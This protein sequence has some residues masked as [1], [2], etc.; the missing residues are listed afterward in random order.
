MLVVDLYCQP[1]YI[2]DMASRRKQPSKGSGRRKADVMQVRVGDSEK[3][4]FEAAAALAGI[5]LSSWVRERLRQAAI[6]ELEA[7]GQ[8]IPLFGDGEGIAP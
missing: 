5:G 8:N 4:T 7:A 3:Q 1:C 6:R 2:S